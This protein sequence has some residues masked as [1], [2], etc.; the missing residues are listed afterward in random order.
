MAVHL[1]FA[2]EQRLQELATRGVRTPDE[3]VQE[4]MDRFLDDYDSLLAAVERGRAAA[5]T[6][7]I[8]DH[9]EVMIMV[10]DVLE[11]G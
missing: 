6:G 3:L 8:V 1:T 11:N 7:D 9:K 4:G 10:D 5:R 2:T